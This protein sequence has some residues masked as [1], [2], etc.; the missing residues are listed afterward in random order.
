[1]WARVLARVGLVAVGLA[2]AVILLELLLQFASLFVEGPLDPDADSFRTGDQRVLALGDS[3][4]YGVWL[5]ERE[6]E[7]YP[8]QLQSVWNETDRLP[9]EVLN[10][11]YPGTNSS[12][13]LGL[14]PGFV[15][16]FAPAVVL[17][18]IGV[19]D[20]WTQPIAL[21]D[22]AAEAGLLGFVKRHSRLY[23]GVYILSRRSGALAL[24]VDY[25]PDSDFERGEG[26]IRAGGREFEVGWTTE[27]GN[28]EKVEAELRQNL[29]GLAD[30]AK[31]SPAQ[32]V[33]LTYPGRFRYYGVANEAI[34]AI[35]AETGTPLIDLGRAFEPLCPEV[36]CPDWLYEDQHPRVQGY[37]LVAETIS[38][39]LPGLLRES[40]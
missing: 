32:L 3:N 33:Y 31:R 19:N 2:L 25:D 1:M 27:I 23:K 22:D 13:L 38:A 36:S 40:N 8:P 29:R 10:L 4:T 12:R 28:P 11:G 37:R 21:A 35:A 17:V 39:R 24:E 34:R 20:F 7:S 26:M 14:Y 15:D 30:L 16:T 6:R 18:M 5:A 9:V